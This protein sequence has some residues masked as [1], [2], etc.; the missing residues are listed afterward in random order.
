MYQ[1]H[2]RIENDIHYHRHPLILVRV[3]L[4]QGHG[5]LSFIPNL[6]QNNVIG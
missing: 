2:N 6:N 4:N 3:L 5:T 1:I